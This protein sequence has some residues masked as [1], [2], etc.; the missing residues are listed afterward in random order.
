[1]MRERLTRNDWLFIA[2]CVLIA[3]G[4]LFVILNWFSRAFPEAALNLKIDRQSSLA[5]A[6]PLLR[7][8]QVPTADLKHTTT[9]ESD[10]ESR[11]FLERTIGLDRQ[12]EEVRRG[13][14]LWAWHHRWFKP[15]QEEEWQLDVAPTGEITGYD[16]KLPEARSLPDLDGPA[17]RALAESFLGQV[18]VNVGGLQ[19][20]S[21]SERRLPHRTQRIFT[22]ESQ[23]L[24]PGGAPYRTVVNVDGNRVTHYA[25]GLKVPDAW[26]RGYSELRSKNSLASGVDSI[27][28]AITTICALIVFIVR[29]RRG[30]VSIA[31]LL[32]VAVVAILLA[33]GSA[34]NSYP[35]QLAAYETT[36]S[37]PTFL[38][39]FVFFGVLFSGFGTAMFLVVLVGAG[40]PVYRERLSW[41]LAMPRLWTARALTSRRVFR[42]FVLGYS[43]VA[44]FIAYQVAF[45]LIAGR[46][47]AWAPAEVPYDAMLSSRFPWIAVLFAGFFPALSEEFMSRAFSVPFFE[48]VFRSRIAA[49]IL[50]GFIWG[51]GHASY[52][53]QPFYIRGVEV[54]LAGV[55]LGF[56]LYRFGLLP[57]LIWHYTVDALYTAIPLFRSG[58]TYYVVSTGVATFVFAIPL[59]LSIALYIRNRGFI[60]DDDL[61][62]ASIPTAPELPR[63]PHESIPL[64]EP[65]RAT[66]WRLLAC[67]LAIAL[68]TGLVI[69]APRG[70]GE[71]IDYRITRDQAIDI[72]S[73]WLGT[74]Q[75][76]APLEKRAAQ[77]AAGFRSWDAGAPV[78]DGGAPPSAFD[79]VAARYLVRHGMRVQDLAG[80]LRHRVPAATWMVRTFTPMQKREYK[81]EVDP[82]TSTVVGY[83]RLQEEKMPGARLD[84]AAA[85]AIARSSFATYGLDA[86]G[87]EVKEA[88]NFQQPARRDWL[89]HFQERTPLVADAWRRVS[90]RVAGNEVSQ[91]ATTVK[92]PDAEYRKAAE[93]TL[94]NLA[95]SLATFAGWLSALALIIAG[96]ITLTRKGH[97]PW[98]PALLWTLALSFIPLA[99]V[100]LDLWSAPYG[101]DTS[102]QWTTYI[103][104]V[105]TS[106]TLTFGLQL[107]ATFLCIAGLLIMYPFVLELGG[108]ESRSRFGR[109]AA[110]AA[111]TAVALF[112]ARRAVMQLLGAA[113]PQATMLHLSVP[114]SV[115]TPFPALFA[116]GSAVEWAIWLSGATAFFWAAVAPFRRTSPW[117]P[118]TV[119]ILALFFIDLS[120]GA[121]TLQIPLMLAD[122][123]SV[124]VLVWIA[125][126][127]ILR[128]N[129]LSYPL[130][131]AL[132]F[133]L[134]E[135][136]TMLANSRFDLKAN[137]IATLGA[138]IALLIWVVLPKPYW[139]Q[140]L[141]ALDHSG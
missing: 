69:L 82:R 97:F 115:A 16:D 56:L 59:L 18:R 141:A 132:L 131:I 55:L 73:R 106:A 7:A 121:D 51:F 102:E 88:L 81:I 1:M 101:Y 45:Y 4:S 42:S 39:K 94:L 99:G 14:H 139:T 116:I 125:A 113:W 119:T 65:I 67:V 118:P 33:A 120:R 43:L 63:E 85:L 25:Q 93:R 123:L 19:L 76:T 5:V 61:T 111:M 130:T 50:A 137:A 46:F 49:V 35:S 47:G 104:R 91:F 54:G 136:A 15:L 20:V 48:R 100:A 26:S 140:P 53:N 6:Q 86:K 134:Q 66:R 41:Q 92:I 64:P 108:R 23:T 114:E 9:F 84:E 38:A 75:H 10:D 27:F 34:I 127:Y 107:G 12:N 95:F 11:I 68:A 98:R 126:R 105:I 60:P 79:S 17:A 21:N 78:E 103:S 24:R 62:N 22:W 74:A 36:E 28:L 2:A 124:A 110:L 89:F 96:L 138:A 58:N 3:A 112:C 71:V 135:G 37:F 13:V 128:D 70:L 32:A 72:A 80:V 57:L 133:L 122:A 83:H 90:I 44:F 29:L 109:S 30:D 52:A 31:M 77:P 129:L 117:V 8:Q 87:F 40:E